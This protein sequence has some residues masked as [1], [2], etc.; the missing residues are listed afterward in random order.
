MITSNREPSEILTMM[1]DPLLAQS[2]MDRL[3]SAAYELE[4]TN[5]PIISHDQHTARDRTHPGS[6]WFDIPCIATGIIDQGLPAR[7][8]GVDAAT[9]QDKSRARIDSPDSATIPAPSTSR[10][11]V[12]STPWTPCCATARRA[13]PAVLRDC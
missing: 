8:S 1:A 4:L 2:A 7:S 5:G 9:G 12:P 10:G 3:Q 11:H 13:A 6:P